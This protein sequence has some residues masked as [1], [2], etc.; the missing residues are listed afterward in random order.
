MIHP[1]IPSP[2]CSIT[3][4][5]CR[6]KRHVARAGTSPAPTLYDVLHRFVQGR[7]R[8]CPRPGRLFAYPIGNIQEEEQYKNGLADVD[9][10]VKVQG[11]GANSERIGKESARTPWQQGQEC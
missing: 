6:D 4:S 5:S 1:G 3:P 7:G 8:A 10:L 11:D 9:K 2:G